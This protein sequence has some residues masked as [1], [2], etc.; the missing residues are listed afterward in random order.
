[1]TRLTRAALPGMIVRGNGTVI[2]VASALAFSASIPAPPLPYRA[3]YA[4][5]K[6]YIVTFSE[7]LAAE[8]K[9]TAVRVQALCP[10]VVRSE[11]HEVA[12]YD[13]SHV[14]FTMEPDDVV[15]ASLAGLELGE[16]VCLPSLSDAALLAKAQE[17]RTR[18]FEGAR[19]ASI[20]AR[21]GAE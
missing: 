3:V 1:M 11:L 9:E 20:A 16:V 13:V 5:A 15:A 8:L 19:S 10:G 18:V 14:P 12:G 2:N 7:L 6:S 17:A 21:Y 4:A